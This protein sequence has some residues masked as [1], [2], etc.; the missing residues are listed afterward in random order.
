VNVGACETIKEAKRLLAP[1][2]VGFSSFDAG[3][4]DL[5]VLNDP[6][7]PCYG[8][9]GGQYS[10]MVNFA[11]IEVVA[12]YEGVGSTIETQREF[13]GR[14]LG[15]NVM[16]LMDLLATHETSSSLLPWQQDRL[17]LR[18]IHALNQTYRAPYRRTI[19][20]SLSAD[21]PPEEREPLEAILRS[22]KADGVPDTI[23][24]LTEDEL[25]AATPEL[26][27]LGYDPDTIRAALAAP[28][29][30]IDYYHHSVRP[31]VIER[32]RTNLK[33]IS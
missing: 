22:L 23:A 18:T 10:F 8:Q 29:Q 2:A 4:A 33:E 13:V 17:I 19:D 11:L 30:S 28:P 16:S 7:K 32:N 24:Y 15:V 21:M 31:S 20:F 6:D 12:R 1:D 9:F 3:T 26:E 25:S 5:R 14:S 27:Q